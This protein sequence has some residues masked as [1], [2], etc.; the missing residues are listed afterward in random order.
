M[1]PVESGID[2]EVFGATRSKRT[3]AVLLISTERG[4]CWTPS[5]A[6]S[7][8]PNETSWRPGWR[9]ARWLWRWN[10]RRLVRTTARQ[11]RR[12]P[13]VVGASDRR[14][15]GRLRWLRRSLRSSCDGQRFE[16]RGSIP[17]ESRCGRVLRWMATGAV[18]SERWWRTQCREKAA[19]EEAGR[20]GEPRD[21]TRTPQRAELTTYLLWPQPLLG[22]LTG[23]GKMRRRLGGYLVAEGSRQDDNAVFSSGGCRC[24][25]VVASLASLGEHSHCNGCRYH[26]R[27]SLN[28]MQLFYGLVRHLSKSHR[29]QSARNDL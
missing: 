3:S 4:S 18:W 23:P 11:A 10:E 5:H 28:L 1:R 19:V 16:E 29:N 7:G 9:P 17:P 20:E 22:T 13:A 25:T 6:T 8:S 24:G 12:P 21:R 27:T 14:G 26:G 2:P 15:A